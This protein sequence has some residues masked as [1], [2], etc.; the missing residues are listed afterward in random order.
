MNANHVPMN[1]L[2]AMEQPKANVILV[3]KDSTW[4]T[5]PVTQHVYHQS[6]STVINI[7]IFVNT[8]VQTIY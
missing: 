5:L 2:H 6:I 1:V 7:I 3:K 8:N 4:R